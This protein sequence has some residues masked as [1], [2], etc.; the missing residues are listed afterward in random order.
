MSRVAGLV[1]DCTRI[2]YLVLRLHVYPN[3]E[4]LDIFF[5]IPASV[6]L[7]AVCLVPNPGHRKQQ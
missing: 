5:F 3:K 4:Y 7:F 6:F 1:G 2:I